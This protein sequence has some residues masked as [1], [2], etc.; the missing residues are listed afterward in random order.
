MKCFAAKQL[1]GA[2]VR[3][4]PPASAPAASGEA[5]VAF[6]AAAQ[7][8]ATTAI[9]LYSMASCPRPAGLRLH[10]ADWGSAK[11]RERSN[12]GARCYENTTLL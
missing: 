11:A 5:L 7:A 12:R 4:S 10:H 8:W 9:S 3:R 6:Y 2:L 1:T